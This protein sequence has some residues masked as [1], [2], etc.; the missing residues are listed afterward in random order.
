MCALENRSLF[1]SAHQNSLTESV[2][3]DVT[4]SFSR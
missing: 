2:E 1:Q 3:L 4:L